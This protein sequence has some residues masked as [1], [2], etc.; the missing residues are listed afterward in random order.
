MTASPGV[1]ETDSNGQLQ[2]AEAVFA[3]DSAVLPD[4]PAQNSTYTI[5]ANAH[6]IGSDYASGRRSVP[7]GASGSEPIPE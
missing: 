6:R 4:L 5:M 3:V 2:G 7:R 1:L